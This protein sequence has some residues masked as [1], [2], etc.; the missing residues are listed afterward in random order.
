MKYLILA[1]FAI[2]LLSSCDETVSSSA[3][4][5]WEA[6]SFEADVDPIPISNGISL[7]PSFKSVAENMDYQ[8]E[9]NTETGE[10]STKGSYTIKTTFSFTNVPD[11]ISS[12]DNVIKSGSFSKVEDN[13]H[14]DKSLFDVITNDVKWTTV[15]DMELSYT[16]T[17]NGNTLIQEQWFNNIEVEDGL[18]GNITLRSEWKK[19]N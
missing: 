5:T 16:L 1:A 14:F 8:L 15:D 13:W 11:M 3:V 6:I 4:T 10:Y 7:A 12:Y 18:K 19:K 9:I 17:D 2:S